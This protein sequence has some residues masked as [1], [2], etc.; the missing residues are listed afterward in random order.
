MEKEMKN[1]MVIS[2]QYLDGN[3][4]TKVMVNFFDNNGI[5][6]NKDFHYGKQCKKGISLFKNTEIY[7]LLKNKYIV[8][9]VTK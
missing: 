3:G 1:I 5:N 8:L 2:K 9:D 7:Y 4:N 6:I